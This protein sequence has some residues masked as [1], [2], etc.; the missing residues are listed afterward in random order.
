MSSSRGRRTLPRLRRRWLTR[1]R[2]T[3]D[4]SRPV[5]PRTM[6]V[7]P[8]GSCRPIARWIRR[9][10]A[11]PIERG[12]ATGYQR[13]A[14]VLAE[15]RRWTAEHWTIPFA[16]EV[17]GRLVGTHPL[18]AVALPRLRVVES[19]AGSSPRAGPG[20]R[21]PGG[22]GRGCFFG[23]RVVGGGGRGVQRLAGPASLSVSRSLGY[24]DDGYELLEAGSSTGCSGCSQARS[25]GG[26]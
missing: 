2:R 16:V 3:S 17:D 22:C 19:A 21:R 13:A 20:G 1:W 12:A 4:P 14:V 6:C 7:P 24:V 18:E 8:P 10:R 5:Q 9:F 25:G 26:G 15:P 11:N 23:L